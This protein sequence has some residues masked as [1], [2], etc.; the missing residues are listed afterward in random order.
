MI[1]AQLQVHLCKTKAKLPTAKM[2]I[3]LKSLQ[4]LI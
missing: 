3:W 2:D 1:Q 4:A